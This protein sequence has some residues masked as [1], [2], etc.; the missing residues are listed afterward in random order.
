[1]SAVRDTAA[2][3]KNEKCSLCS[4]GFFWRAV[5]RGERLAP[6]GLEHPP[7]CLEGNCSIRLGYGQVRPAGGPL[8]I[9]PAT[10]GRSG[11]RRSRFPVLLLQDGL[12]HGG[13]QLGPFLKCQP[14]MGNVTLGFCSH[15][16]SRI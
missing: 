6:E 10:G 16:C 15:V 13:Q 14:A 5:S 11:G 7:H 8:R 4:P 9:M 3:K 2:K 1:M 12:V